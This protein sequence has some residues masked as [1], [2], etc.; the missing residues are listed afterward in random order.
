M[1]HSSSK[2]VDLLLYRYTTPQLDDLMPISP[3]PE[4]TI[5]LKKEIIRR[6]YKKI[7][8]DTPEL[9]I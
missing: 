3:N 2:M 4:S 1:F 6:H 8:K 9:E 5:I 7:L